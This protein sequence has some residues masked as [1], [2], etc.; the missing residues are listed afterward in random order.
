[1]HVNGKEAMQSQQ[2]IIVESHPFGTCVFKTFV[3]HEDVLLRQSAHPHA[4]K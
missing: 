1:M 3:D 4:R 2:V